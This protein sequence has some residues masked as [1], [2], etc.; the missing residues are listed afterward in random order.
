MCA[1][2]ALP[3]EMVCLW[4]LKISEIFYSGDFNFSKLKQLL[5]N[6]SLKSGWTS[7]SQEGERAGRSGLGSG[8]PSS[9]P[10]TRLQP[11]GVQEC[12]PAQLGAWGFSLFPVRLPGRPGVSPSPGGQVAHACH[13]SPSAGVPAGAPRPPVC[14]PGAGL[15]QHSRPGR[16]PCESS[17]YDVGSG[18]PSGPH[19]V[20]CVDF[21]SEQIGEPVAVS[22]ARSPQAAPCPSCHSCTCS[23]ET[24]IKANFGS[25]CL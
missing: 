17:V 8:T 13:G 3:A 23:L 5:G 24:E 10:L 1:S 7:R 6:S 2:T 21:V 11:G 14:P 19:L 22:W 4:L 18:A 9:C 16:R 15:F 12:A 20:V 25:S